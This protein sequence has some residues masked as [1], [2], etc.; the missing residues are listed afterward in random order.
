MERGALDF[1]ALERPQIQQPQLLLFAALQF[2]QFD[3][4]GAPLPVE[5]GGALQ[6]F[7]MGGESVQHIA[8]GVGGEEK[9]LVVL[10]VNIAQVRRQFLEQ[11]DRHGTAAEEGAR[12]SSGQNLALHQQLAVLDFE[13]RGLQQ[14][15]YGRMIAHIE[16]ARHAGAGFPGAHHVGGGAASQ[17]QSQGVHYDRFSAAG[18]PGQQV[19]ATM[20]ADA[21]ALHH[22]VVFHHQLLQHACDYNLHR[23][24]G[25][26]G[27]ALSAAQGIAVVIPIY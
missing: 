12:L 9:L 17:Q 21:Q 25:P 13:P 15:A 1:L 11:R 19:Q 6:R 8:L 27:R 4:G 23:R 14:P 22:G 2:F 7:A 16:D 20:E 26:L 5:R 24:G 3:G 18:F 10:P